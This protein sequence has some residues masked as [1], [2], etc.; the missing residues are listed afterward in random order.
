[1][2]SSDL[3]VFRWAR[4]GDRLGNPSHG[5]DTE[6]RA[7]VTSCVPCGR[8]RTS[9]PVGVIE[10]SRGSSE[11]NTPGTRPPHT[12]GTPE[13]CMNALP[14][15]LMGAVNRLAAYGRERRREKAERMEMIVQNGPT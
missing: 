3:V 10:I 7:P 8:G 4:S 2:C 6:V 14:S 13:G 9:T 1:M 15:G 12:P 5:A 11:A